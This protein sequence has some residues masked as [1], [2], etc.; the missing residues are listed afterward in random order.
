[1]AKPQRISEENS[2]AW[3]AHN[4]DGDTGNMGIEEH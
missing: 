1:M 4:E 3:R 2:V